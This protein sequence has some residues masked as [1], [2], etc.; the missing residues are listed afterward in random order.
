[1]PALVEA[2][3]LVKTYATPRG[4][5][6]AV[7]GLDLDVESGEFLAVSGRSGSGKSTLLGL[8]GGLCRP[9]GGTV[10]VDDTD[11]G[12]L[13][14]GP[15]AEFRARRLGFMFQFA[16]LLPNLRAVDNIALAALLGGM[17]SREATDRARDLLRQVGLAERWDAYPGELSGGQ[18]RRVALARALIN[19]PALLM[20]D[21]PTSDLDEEAEREVVGM[22]DGLRRA[23]GATLIV[24]THDRALARR[25]DRVI[26]LRAGRLVSVASPGP[27]GAEHSIRIPETSDSSFE[28]EPTLAPAEPTPLGAGLGRFLVGFVGWVLAFAAGLYAIDRAA[29]QLQRK[30]LATRI[31]RRKKSEELALQQLRADVS[32]VVSRPDGR[33]E[34]SLYLENFDPGRPFY[35][36]GPKAS[37]FVQVNQTWEPIPVTAGEGVEDAVHPVTT[38]QV[39]PITFRADLERFDELIRG[40][41]HVRIRS[42]MI[43]GEAAG[44]TGDLFER[45]DDY[46]LYLKPQSLSDDEVR[47]RNGWKPGA[48]VPR[49]IAMPPH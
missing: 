14:P 38:R 48:L 34:L 22:L 45:D 33:F 4:P 28:P 41:M 37:V 47:R 19:R 5:I 29:A 32:D 46:Y 26:H 6:A 21:E 35:V 40:Y 12:A 7:D 42:V 23:H 30:D 36:L 27:V 11:L 39:F 16:G 10:R 15:L 18:Q 3:G 44:P 13:G 20:A 2:R 31:E 49:W 43:V 9:T 8:I 24:V 25:A 1:M 17:D